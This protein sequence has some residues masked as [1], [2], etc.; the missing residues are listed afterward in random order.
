M[1]HVRRPKQLGINLIYDEGYDQFMTDMTPRFRSSRIQNPTL[2][3]VISFINDT[4]LL[5]RKARN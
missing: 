5:H 2:L 1:A 3:V 4:V